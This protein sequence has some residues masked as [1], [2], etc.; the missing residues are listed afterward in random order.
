MGGKQG[1]LEG[2]GKKIKHTAWNSQ[3]SN[4]NDGKEIVGK[5]SSYLFI[6]QTCSFSVKFLRVF[7]IS[8]SDKTQSHEYD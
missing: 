1:D 2:E 6:F 5:G 4:K 7:R 3:R 8:L